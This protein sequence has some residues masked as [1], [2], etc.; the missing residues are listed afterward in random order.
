[1]ASWQQNL[2]FLVLPVCHL[3]PDPLDFIE[4]DFIGAAVVELGGASARRD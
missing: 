4:G 3:N 2:L 1:M